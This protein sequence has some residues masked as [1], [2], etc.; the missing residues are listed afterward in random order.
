MRI[1]Q[2]APTY[3]RVPPRGYGGIEL[4][5]HLVTEELV[6]RGHDVTLYATGDS[7]TSARLSSVIPWPYR[8]GADDQGVRH[9]EYPHLANVQAAFAD[10]AEGR[11]DLIHNHAGLEGVVLAAWSDTPVLTTTHGAWTPEA[12]ATWDRYPWRHHQVSANQAATYP[13]HGRLA[14]VHHGIDLSR[15]RP[16]IS[17]SSAESPLVFLGRFA[18]AKGPEVAIDVARRT[19]RPLLMAG[20]VDGGDREWFER[21]VA[22]LVDGERIRIVG[23]VG[24]AGKAELLACAA[25]LLFPIVWDEP[26]G[27]VV[28]EALASGTPVVAFRRGSVP[29][30]IDDG[31]TGFLVDDADAMADAVGRV[32]RLD[33]AACRVTAERRFSVERMVDDLLSR[34]EE[35]IALGPNEPI[36]GRVCARIG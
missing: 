8:Y 21:D 31:V 22:P 16:R 18:P 4:I 34:Y 29:E 33:R 1:A 2:L 7:E 27:L 23:E 32:D 20:K 19:R 13:A 9:A 17:R 30:L 24:R 15:F 14:P 12:L 35:T 5:V 10:A 3:E 6:R 25:A 28:V 11:Y 36:V 26:F